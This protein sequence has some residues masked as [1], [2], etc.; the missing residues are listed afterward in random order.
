[1]I[2]RPARVALVTLLLT[3]VVAPAPAAAQRRRAFSSEG[4]MRQ[5]AKNPVMPAYPEAALRDGVQ[6][7]AV[8]L[9]SHDSDT[10]EVIR[11]EILKAPDESIAEAVR[12]TLKQWK[13]TPSTHPSTMGVTIQGTLRFS[14]SIEEGRGRVQYGPFEGICSQKPGTKMPDGT[15]R[16]R[17]EDIDMGCIEK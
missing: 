11:V 4:A 15:L 3:S 1:M 5:F 10:G 9:V 2:K 13:F 6:G 12:D 17:L 7:L 8:A 14:F 16:Q